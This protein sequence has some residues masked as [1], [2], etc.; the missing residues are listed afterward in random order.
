[1]PTDIDSN[2]LDDIKNSDE[3]WVIDFWADWCQPC[4]KL[5]PIYEDV[6]EE[7]DDVNFGKVD[8]EEHQELGTSMGVR[9]LPTM[10]IMKGDEEVARTSGMK[11]KEELKGWIQENS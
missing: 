8:M 9:A 2:K 6:S 7:I 1:M 3:T 10:I 4:K 5:A 11:K